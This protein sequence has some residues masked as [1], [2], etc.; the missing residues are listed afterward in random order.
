MPP[1]A[2]SDFEGGKYIFRV[3]LTESSGGVLGANFMRKRNVIFDADGGRVDFADSNCNYEDYSDAYYDPPDVPFSMPPVPAPIE[4]PKDSNNCSMEPAGYC[5][6]LCD[7][8]FTRRALRQQERTGVDDKDK[9]TAGNGAGKVEYNRNKNSGSSSGDDIISLTGHINNK[10]DKNKDKNN[11][12]KDKSKKATDYVSEGLQTFFDDCN[13][14]YIK[15]P[16][17]EYCTADNE[18]ARGASVHCLDTTWSECGK[19]CTQHRMVGQSKKGQCTHQKEVRSCA[20]DNCPQQNSDFFVFADLKFWFPAATFPRSWEKIFE[21]DLFSAF[22]AI[23]KIPAGNMDMLVDMETK[24]DD[25][26]ATRRLSS[27]RHHDHMGRRRLVREKVK[28]YVKL[29]LQIVISRKLYPR[30][31]Y[32]NNAVQFVLE[33]LDTEGFRLGDFLIPELAIIGKQRDGDRI[34]RYSMLFPEDI[35]VQRAVA[36]P[37]GGIRDPINIPNAIPIIAEQGQ[38]SAGTTR[39]YILIGVL[40]G[41]VVVMSIVCMLYCRLKSEYAALA[42]E[43]VLSSGTSIVRMLKRVAPKSNN[44]KSQE[45]GRDFFPSARGDGSGNDL[46]GGGDSD[47]ENAEEDGL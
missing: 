17:M 10:N 34:Y 19:D 25:T 42:K 26:E 5:S 14:T 27:S 16:C 8:T 24:S 2:Y 47:D 6:A 15:R 9:S 20:V 12:N 37:M 39:E 31:E 29:Q 43:K 38:S 41:C 36:L 3:Y 40:L 45:N 11:K 4:L 13:G 33:M 18:I 23:L 46:L 7:R 21:D 28:H 32:F 35:I 22:S 44:R 30:V 1:S